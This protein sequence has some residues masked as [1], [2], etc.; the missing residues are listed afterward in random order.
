MPR[1]PIPKTRNG[2]TFTEAQFRGWIRS[3]LRRMS[4]RWKPIYQT[5]NRSKRAVTAA[6][7]E[8]W[9]NRIKFVHQCD[10]CQQWFPKKQVAV[11]HIV[12][13]GS[14]LDIEKDTGPFI[15][16]LLCEVDGL[17]L[18]CTNCHQEK[19]NVENRSGVSKIVEEK[20]PAQGCRLP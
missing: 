20:E 7:R 14:L 11:D 13:C 15:L 16:R 6:D 5:F 8:K 17:Q 2:G 19:T 3:S 9:G 1:Q 12:P 4:Q 18:L 10:A